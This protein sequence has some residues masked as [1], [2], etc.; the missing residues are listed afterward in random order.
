MTIGIYK[1]TNKITGTVLVGQSVAIE[2]RRLQYLALLRKGK[3][4]NKHFQNSWSKYGEANFEFCIVEEIQCNKNDAKA[5]LTALEQKWLDFYKLKGKVYN[6]IGPVDSP[7]TGRKFPEDVRKKMSFKLI[8]NQHTKGYSPTQETRAK[9]SAAF[10]GQ[11]NHRWGTIMSESHKQKL[12]K[13]HE[14]RAMYTDAYKAK[15][16]KIKKGIPHSAETREK[17]R[18]ARG[19]KKILC[20]GL[21]GVE[22][23]FL[24][25]NDACKHFNVDRKCIKRHILKNIPFKDFYIR[26]EEDSC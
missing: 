5:T 20:N 24:S 8:G 1:W 4:N 14:S 3:W 15:M 9:L 13:L 18:V 21:D 7:N 10:T 6:A 25:Q 22:V 2:R 16:S 26:Y 11:K 12:I 23:I 19:A 17:I